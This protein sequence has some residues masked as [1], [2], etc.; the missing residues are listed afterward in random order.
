MGRLL[1]TLLLVERGV[2]VK[3]LLYM[4]LYLKQNR[5]EYY[6]LLQRVR[7]DG[8][9]EAWILFFLRGVSST[10]EKAV[11][12]AKDLLSLFDKD[13]QKLD[14]VGGK[15]GSAQQVL[16][17]LQEMPYTSIGRL[18][19]ATGLS[20]NTVTSSL[21]LLKSKGIVS[22]VDGRRGRLFLYYNYIQLMDEGTL[23]D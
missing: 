10:A 7:H 12:L 22:E 16:T 2:L 9:W 17:Q 1:I 23:A 5:N 14:N 21:E 18:A 4:S 6:A 13:L 11:A 20:F 19:E 8:D 15:R 3:P